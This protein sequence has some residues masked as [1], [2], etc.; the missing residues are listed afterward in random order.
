MPLSSEPGIVLVGNLA[1]VVVELVDEL[2]VCEQV[3]E[4]EVAEQVDELRYQCEQN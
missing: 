3:D 2:E 4:L 1:V